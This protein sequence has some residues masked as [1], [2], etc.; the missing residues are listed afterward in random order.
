MSFLATNVSRAAFSTSVRAS[1]AIKEFVV[2]GGGLMGSGIAQVGAQTGH[3]VTLVDISEDVLKKSE[4][5]I[6]KSIKQVIVVLATD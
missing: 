1:S 3:K 5:R 6:S 4:A 2:I